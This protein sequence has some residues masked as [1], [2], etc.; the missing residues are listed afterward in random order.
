MWELNHKV[1]W[2]P[3]NWCFWAV[4]LEKTLESLL[5]YQEIKPVNPKGNQTW[6]FIGRIYAE[7]AALIFWPPFVKRR[8]IR[9]YLDDGKDWRQKE[10]GQQM[11]R[12]LGNITNSMA[13]NLSKLQ[14]TVENRGAW[15]AAVHGVTKSQTWFCDWTTTIRMLDTFFMAV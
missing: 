2:A 11:M 1:G 7:A 14:E 15:L 6:I 13:M 9:K 3:K 5:D 10:R 4:V 12:W 8:P